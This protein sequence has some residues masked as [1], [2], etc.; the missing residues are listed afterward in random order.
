MPQPPTQAE[1]INIDNRMSLESAQSQNL[2]EL[3]NQFENYT[4]Y[5][6]LNSEEENS[7]ND[8][9]FYPDKQAGKSS[10]N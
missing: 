2:D 6:S 10:S 4:E 1:E 8:I 5:H 9:F 3:L 7:D